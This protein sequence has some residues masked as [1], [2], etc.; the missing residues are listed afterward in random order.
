[1]SDIVGILIA[2]GLFAIAAS[3]SELAKA[4]RQPGLEKYEWRELLQPL[5]RIPTILAQI[6][7]SQ[8]DEK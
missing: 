3:I 8:R 7:D 5:N 4:V 2:L 6:R 1:V